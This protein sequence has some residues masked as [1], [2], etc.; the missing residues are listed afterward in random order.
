MQQGYGEAV[1]GYQYRFIAYPTRGTAFHTSTATD[2]G[3]YD[4]GK[5][6]ECSGRLCARAPVYSSGTSNSC[7]W[8]HSTSAL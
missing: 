6:L 5:G 1:R 4:D 7:P 8:N 3:I 2:G